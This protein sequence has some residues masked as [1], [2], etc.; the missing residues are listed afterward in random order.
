MHSINHFHFNN[1]VK[2]FQNINT[3]LILTNL[4]EIKSIKRAYKNGKVKT[5]ARTCPIS[6]FLLSP[7][8]CH[9]TGGCVP[10]KQS[11]CI[12]LFP[13]DFFSQNVHTK[14]FTLNSPVFYN[15]RNISHNERF[16]YIMVK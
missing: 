10:C 15:G 13:S 14:C 1:A 4:N 6:T 5:S 12:S 11:S 7:Q 9:G 8:K 2:N 16:H 3:I